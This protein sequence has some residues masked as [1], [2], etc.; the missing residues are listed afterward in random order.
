MYEAALGWSD[1]PQSSSPLE[2]WW[3]AVPTTK[4][5]LER[6]GGEQRCF[7]ESESAIATSNDCQRTGESCGG[8]AVWCC[9]RGFPQASALNSGYIP[10]SHRIP[11]VLLVVVA[12][13]VGAIAWFV[14]SHIRAQRALSDVPAAF[15]GRL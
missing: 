3:G 7:A 8:G 13:A 2:W 11:G 5:C 9:P 15:A 4:I 6:T 14:F 10:T 1:V 12:G